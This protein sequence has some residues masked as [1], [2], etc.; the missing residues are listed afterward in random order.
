[1]NFLRRC[2]CIG[3]G[4]KMMIL[5]YFC[6]DICYNT[7]RSDDNGRDVFFIQSKI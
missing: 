7:I 3:S 5:L 4:R 2:S 1:M 6:A